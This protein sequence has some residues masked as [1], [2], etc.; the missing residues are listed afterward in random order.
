MRFQYSNSHKMKLLKTVF[1]IIL[2]IFLFSNNNSELKCQNKL[3][4][5]KDDKTI[6]LDS[7]TNNPSGIYYFIDNK[8]ITE[9]DFYEKALNGEMG[10]NIVGVAHVE[11]KKAILL[12][13][14]RYRKGISIWKTIN[15]ENNNNESDK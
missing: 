10:K 9:R 5:I 7:I 15:K 11:G 2:F 8:E 3:N 6:F 1:F 4:K 12:F 14:E 13:G